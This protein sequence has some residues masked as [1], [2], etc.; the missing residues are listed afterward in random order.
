MVPGFLWKFLSSKDYVN[1]GLG[2]VAWHDG[3]IVA[4]ASS[5]TVYQGGIEIEIVT[6]EN[7]RQRGLAS[8]CG[9]ALILACLQKDS[10]PSWDTANT[11]VSGAGK[12]WATIMTGN[13]WPTAFL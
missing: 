11:E 10:H 12:S 4:G 6:H 13:I 9:A 3:K 8:A 5:C 7:Y 2:F 1:R